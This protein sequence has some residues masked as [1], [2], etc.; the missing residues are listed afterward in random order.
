MDKNSE[1]LVWIVLG[2]GI[3]IFVVGIGTNVLVD[4]VADKVIQKLQKDYS[5]SPYGPGFDPD[6]IDLT[7]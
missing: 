7:K 4:K 3:F 5:P 6:K 2:L 1:K